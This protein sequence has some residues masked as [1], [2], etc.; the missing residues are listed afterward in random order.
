LTRP[1]SH[2]DREGRSLQLD[3]DLDRLSGRRGTFARLSA[4]K[5]TGEYKRRKK[6]QTPL[7]G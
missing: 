2:R 4:A 5:R 7:Q 6:E 1:Y 3:D